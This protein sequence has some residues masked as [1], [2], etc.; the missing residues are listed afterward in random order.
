MDDRL[1]MWA[2]N[3]AMTT[4]TAEQAVASL[5]EA[6]AVLLAGEDFACERDEFNALLGQVCDL[7]NIDTEDTD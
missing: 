6:A 4:R 5:R 1:S 2:L 3:M 7:L